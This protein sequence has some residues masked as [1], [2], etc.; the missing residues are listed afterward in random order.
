MFKANL[1]KDDPIDD[2]EKPLIML[3]DDDEPNLKVLQGLLKRSYNTVL[4]NSAAS[5]LEM[6][7]TMPAP[8]QIK[9]IVSD[10][11]MPNMTGVE[12]FEHVK[13]L[14]PD[15]VRIILTGYTDVRAI[16]DSI[17]KAKIYQF[18]SKP[19][20]PPD[21]L[22]SVMRACEL[23]DM[24][25][26]LRESD[27]LKREFINTIRH[28]LRTP[29]NGIQGGIELIKDRSAEL[30]QAEFISIIEESAMQMM[31]MVTSIL[32]FTA[33]ESGDLEN[34]RVLTD[35]KSAFDELVEH[36]RLQAAA[37]SVAFRYQPLS[38]SL[39]TEI[40]FGKLQKILDYILVNAQKFTP[41]G[42]V[43]FS[44]NKEQSESALW[45]NLQVRDSG[46]GIPADKLDY[47]FDM[48]TQVD[49]SYSR[50]YGGLG[51]G[52]ALAKKLASMLDGHITVSSTLGQGSC[53]NVRIPIIEIGNIAAGGEGKTVLTPGKVRA[54][55]AQKPLVAVVEDNKVNQLVL[56]KMLENKGCTVRTFDNGLQ[57]ANYTDIAAFDLVFMDCQ[58]PVMDG[59]EATRKV[60][61]AGFTHDK[62]VIVACTA[63]VSEQDKDACLNAG[64]DDF[65]GKPLSIE[66][67]AKVLKQHLEWPPEGAGET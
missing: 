14:L 17:N 46:I 52:L 31:G 8:E 56:Q 57:F 63:N 12:F 21:L 11:R 23:Y 43:E 50:K 49:G 55:K 65:I 13:D 7:D 37:G 42:F 66:K 39:R 1:P 36:Y 62:L 64:M 60:R 6:L 22:I 32:D 10:Q 34:R 28:E 45:L 54:I 2:S 25:I 9:V 38:E 24:R 20:Q 47:I 4:C 33:F 67:I 51:V 35:F 27:K 40:D 18:I 16:I 48:F 59:F 15:T 26:K 5:A 30:G 53:F 19:C 3:I 58:M 29:M 44:V 41:S 61:D